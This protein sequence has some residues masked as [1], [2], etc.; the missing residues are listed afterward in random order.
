LQ[1]VL[2]KFFRIT[3]IRS[4][5]PALAASQSLPNRF[6]GS[7]RCHALRVMLLLS[8]R[9]VAYYRTG[10]VDT[11]KRLAA[12]AGHRDHLDPDADFGVPATNAL[13]A[14]NI[15]L[16]EKTPTTAPGVTT[17]ATEQLASM[18]E[19]GKPLVVDTMD[20]SWYRS[21]PERSDSISTAT[22]SARPT[23]QRSNASRRSCA[24]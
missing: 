17:V 16:G 14:Y 15:V 22:R 10:D 24:N 7:T 9:A 4:P 6:A 19:H 11:A 13:H 8:A 2:K 12:E 3:L 21:V 20:A 1:G 23:T 5:W 18:L